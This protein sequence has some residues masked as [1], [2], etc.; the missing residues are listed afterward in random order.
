MGPPTRTLVRNFWSMIPVPGSNH[1]SKLPPSLCQRST[2]RPIDGQTEIS[3]T[4]GWQIWATCDAR[5]YARPLALGGLGPRGELSF[6]FSAWSRMFDISRLVQLGV[7]RFFSRWTWLD[8][9]LEGRRFNLP[10]AT[11]SSS[12]DGYSQLLSLSAIW[13]ALSFKTQAAS[14]LKF[15]NAPFWT[16]MSMLA[17]GPEHFYPSTMA[18]RFALRGNDTL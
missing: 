9:Q 6:Y 14:L 12:I 15:R 7:H 1:P 8:I 11:M 17:V 5:I 3:V 16:C 10:V 4:G 18:V 13:H 2:G